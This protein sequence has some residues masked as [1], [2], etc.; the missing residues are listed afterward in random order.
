[1]NSLPYSRPGL[2]GKWHP[3]FTLLEL[4]L[5][6][7]VMVILAGLAWPSLERPFSTHRLRMAADHV[8]AQWTSTRVDA[9]DSGEVLLFRYAPGS[10]RYRIERQQP[11]DGSTSSTSGS[12]SGSSGAANSSASGSKSSSASSGGSGSGGTSGGDPLP[13]S[14]ARLP[15][16]RT[17]P[18]GVNFASGDVSSSDDQSD[19]TQQLPSAADTT[20]GSQSG[21]SEPILFYIDG[22]CSNARL[23]LKNDRD[24]SIEVT[25]R[26]LTGVTTVGEIQGNQGGRRKAG[27]G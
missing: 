2:L 7:A 19:P 12:P 26:G 27:G 17:L 4:T 8:R 6:L 14:V 21:W 25:L 18:D 5:V 3:A 1:L 23:V 22:T 9:M 15:R 13:A 20:A 24:F 10:N 16:E 11:D